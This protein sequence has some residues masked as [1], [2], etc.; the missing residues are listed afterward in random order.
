MDKKDA[1]QAL[2]NEQTDQALE[3][4]FRQ[5]STIFVGMSNKTVMQLSQSMLEEEDKPPE[6][7]PIMLADR[8]PPDLRCPGC[9]TGGRTRI[10]MPEKDYWVA[11]RTM[12]PMRG[13][14]GAGSKMFYECE[15]DFQDGVRH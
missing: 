2:H 8:A 12:L 1:A 13:A 10:Y 5:V 14:A 11:R 4:I 7:T 15:D 6:V 3:G 9:L